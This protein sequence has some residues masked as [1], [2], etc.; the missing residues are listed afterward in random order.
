MGSDLPSTLISRIGLALALALVAPHAL[1]ETDQDR[2][3]ARKLAEEG[4]DAVAQGRYGA[5]IEAYQ[6]AYVLVTAP[7]LKVAIARVELAQHH[8]IE[9]QQAFYDAARSEP[10]TNEPSSWADA[11]TSA[12]REAEA[13]TPRLPMID[14]GFVGLGAGTMVHVRIDDSPLP[15]ADVPRA[16][17]PGRHVIKVDGAGYDE[18]TTV[19]VVAEGERKHVEVR[20]HETGVRA[21]PTSSPDASASA[22]HIPWKPIAI[23]SLVATGVFTGVGIATG[24]V[25]SS[26]VS[27]LNSKYCTGHHCDNTQAARDLRDQAKALGDV[28]TA[29]FVAAGASAVVAGISLYENHHET[30]ENG[31][32]ALHLQLTR[33]DVRLVGRF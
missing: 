27:D 10:R 4:D 16:V 7:T 31:L 8:L 29:S 1:A 25:S 6:K 23:T 2:A 28:S 15:S 32:R 22:H 11:R 14:L 24:V 19:V 12:R 21:I 20:L 9:A 26:K 5:A 18:S 3:S 13:L 30:Q 33:Q 17:D